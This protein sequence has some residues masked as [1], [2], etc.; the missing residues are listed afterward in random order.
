[1]RTGN[2]VGDYKE[3]LVVCE[4]CCGSGEVELEETEILEL[5]MDKTTPEEV[6]DIVQ[7]YKRN[8]AITCPECNGKGQWYEKH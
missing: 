2:C 8:S 4:K 1:M 7:Q 3:E 6:F 5:L